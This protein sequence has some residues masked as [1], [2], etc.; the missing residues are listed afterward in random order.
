MQ[1]QVQKVYELLVPRSREGTLRTI[2]TLLGF[3]ACFLS[4]CH[5]SNVKEWKLNQK[6]F[7]FLG[8]AIL[9]LCQNFF[10]EDRSV[11][12]VALTWDSDQVSHLVKHSW[13]ISLQSALCPAQETSLLFH[14]FLFVSFQQL[15]LF[16]PKSMRSPITRGQEEMIFY[17]F[18][19]MSLWGA[20]CLQ[21]GP[22][23]PCRSML[24]L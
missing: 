5:L 7:C 2:R 22:D 9:I 13:K 16:S 4:S 15:F 21:E 24:W 20:S 6:A 14:T 23:T 19:S 10:P 11:A 1:L 18:V 8:M 17:D 3:I 12:E